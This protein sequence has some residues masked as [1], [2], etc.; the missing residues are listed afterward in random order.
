MKSGIR[1]SLLTSIALF[2]GALWLEAQAPAAS[3]ASAEHDVFRDRR[4]PGKGAD[5]GG[6]EGADRYCQELA[7]RQVPAAKPG[8]P[9]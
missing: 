2:S 7:Q 1:F 3:T 5:L 9:I 8:E 6:I 4:G